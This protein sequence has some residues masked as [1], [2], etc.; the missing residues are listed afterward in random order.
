[1]GEERETRGKENEEKKKKKRKKGK[2][3]KGGEKKRIRKLIGEKLA[4][5]QIEWKNL[6]SEK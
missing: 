5:H 3:K 4:R 1:M 6:W 2:G